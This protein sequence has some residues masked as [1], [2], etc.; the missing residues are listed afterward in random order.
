MADQVA[1]AGIAAAVVGACTGFFPYVLP[2]I[3]ARLRSGGAQFLGCMVVVLALDAHVDVAPPA[4]AVVPLL[5]LTLP[6]V[7]GLLVSTARLRD[8]GADAMDAGLPGRWRALGIPRLAKVIGLTFVQAGLAFLAVCVARTLVAPE[9]GAAIG[10]IVALLLA[11]PALFV[12]GDWTRKRFPRLAFWLAGG[13]IAVGLVL[14]VPAAL[15]MWRARGDANAAADAIQR[16]LDA[17]RDGNTDDRNERIQRRREVLRGGGT[18]TR[19]PVRVARRASTDRRA[20]LARPRV[21][22]PT[23]VLDCPAPADG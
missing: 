17:V 21:S 5:L 6:L 18:E 15:A 1:V 20:Q 8:H 2:P 22:S 4:A 12:K 14:T 9:W 19:R 10:V 16:G 7:D 13:L 23:S 11:L 3:A